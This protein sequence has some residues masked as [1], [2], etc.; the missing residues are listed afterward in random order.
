MREAMNRGRVDFPRI[1]EPVHPNIP[2]EEIFDDEDD[3]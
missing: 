3:E 2:D 1:N